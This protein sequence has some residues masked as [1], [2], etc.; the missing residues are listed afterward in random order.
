MARF[1]VRSVGAMR[2]SLGTFKTAG[3]P[4]G[5]ASAGAVARP[6]DLGYWSLWILRLKNRPQREW[7]HPRCSF[8][9][10]SI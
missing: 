8:I 6:A 9:R 10:Y 5:T 7:P 4:T 1:G 3:N 2:S